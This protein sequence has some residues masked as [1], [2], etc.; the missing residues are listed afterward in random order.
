MTRRCSYCQDSG[1]GK[2]KKSGGTLSVEDD[3]FSFLF[4]T[5][6]CNLIP[7]VCFT[8]KRKAASIRLGCGCGLLL[9][10][11]VIGDAF[12]VEGDGEI[13]CVRGVARQTSWALFFLSVLCWVLGVFLDRLF[14]GWCV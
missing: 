9:G 12:A 13:D 6:C 5:L 11:A 3:F 14:A 1:G 8:A 2:R 7:G 10:N 4:T